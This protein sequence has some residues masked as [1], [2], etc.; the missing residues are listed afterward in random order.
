[1]GTRCQYVGRYPVACGRG[2]CIPLYQPSLQQ[3]EKR[4]GVIWQLILKGSCV[5]VAAM[6]WAGA[7]VLLFRFGSSVF[8]KLN[9]KFW[10]PPISSKE[11]KQVGG[12]KIDGFHIFQGI[13]LSFLFLSAVIHSELTWWYQWIG[14]S[15]IWIIV[16]P[17]TYGLLSPLHGKK[18]V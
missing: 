15:V 6:F 10:N 5:A 18:R 16:F 12:F 9:P 8:R 17:V 3:A 11:A 4:E 14:M 13:A 7:S 1:M 2:G